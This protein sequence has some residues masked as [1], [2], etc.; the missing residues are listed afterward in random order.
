MTYQN[1]SISALRAEDETQQTSHGVRPLSAQRLEKPKK[2]VVQHPTTPTAVSMAVA[3]RYL[4]GRTA[5]ST[6]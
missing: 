3:L 5:V 2:Q 4:A 6:P 1:L